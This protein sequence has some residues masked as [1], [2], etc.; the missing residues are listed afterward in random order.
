MIEKLS[1]HVTTNVIG[2]DFVSNV[3]NAIN[4]HEIVSTA[5]FT[6]FVSHIFKK[7]YKRSKKH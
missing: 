3:G 1:T 5:L 4:F 2:L 7:F 6:T